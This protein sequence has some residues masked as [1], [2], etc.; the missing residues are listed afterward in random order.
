MINK[1]KIRKTISIDR[2]LL[3]KIEKL[4]TNKSILIEKLLFDFAIDNSIIT[5]DIIL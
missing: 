5:N 2:E 3:K 1:Q 4:T